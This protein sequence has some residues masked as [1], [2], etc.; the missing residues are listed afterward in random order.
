MVD[1]ETEHQLA[2]MTT[3][4]LANRLRSAAPCVALL[5]VGSVEPHGPHLPLATDTLIG[6][7]A[8]ERAVRQLRARGITALIAPSVGY[9]VTDFAAGFAGALS[10]PAAALTSFLRAVV[11]A[12]LGAGFAH[13]CVVN[14]HLEPEHDAAVRASVAGLPAGKASVASPLTRRWARTLSAEFKSGACHAGRYETSL[15]LAAAPERV[16]TEVAQGLPDL[17]ISLSKGIQ[18][19]QSTFLAMGMDAAYTGAP[20]EASAEE[21]SD[22]LERL[23]EM[24][25]TEVTEGLAELGATPTPVAG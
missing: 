2:R 10:I 20:R 21:G 13:V 25:A 17:G 19:G 4:A 14:N 11:E 22:L 8:A 7:A 12:H 5:P 9:G 24:I 18:A 16:H 23:A 3:Q 6:E 15:I 1:T